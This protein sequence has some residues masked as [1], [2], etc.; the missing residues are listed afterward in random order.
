MIHELRRWARHGFVSALAVFAMAGVGATEGP[1]YQWKDLGDLLDGQGETIAYAI[2]HKGEIVGSTT[3]LEGIYT[4]AF[5][6]R[7]GKMKALETFGGHTSF[8]N[9]VNR[10]GQIA[11]G[12]Y[13][14]EFSLHAF[15]YSDH[16]VVDL[17]TLG[18]PDSSATGLND[19]GVV[20]GW[21]QNRR[22][23]VHAVVWR[24]GRLR[25]LGAFEGNYSVAT[26][27]NNA[28][29]IVG[30]AYDADDH[31]HAFVYQ[32]DQ[33]TD[34]NGGNE[35]SFAMAISDSGVVVGSM[36]G[37]DHVHHPY[38]YANGQM[39]DLGVPL[40]FGAWANAINGAG[41]IVGACALD[42]TYT[43]NHAYLW[44]AGTATDLNL[45]I[46]PDQDPATGHVTLNGAFAIND[47]GQIVA[48]G[49]TPRYAGT[50]SFLLTPR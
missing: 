17:G 3:S 41:A 22:F 28:G 32:N 42:V 5:A 30:Y 7:G 35:V 25:D 10:K 20:V 18:G 29:T 39:T 1:R 33:M 43:N 11:G 13:V 21:S 19:H 46:D 27:I 2:N 37:S 34:I 40:G 23:R 31:P 48:F 12:A 44:E 26:A 38:S 15:L 45:L 50:R 9:G 14:T 6:Y 4:T 24:A 16:A 8:A 47:A 49:T 36:F